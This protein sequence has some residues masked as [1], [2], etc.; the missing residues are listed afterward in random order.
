MKEVRLVEINS[1][2]NSEC[3]YFDD[4]ERIV[5]DPERQRGISEFYSEKSKQHKNKVLSRG[6]VCI[7]A[8]VVI[9]S[10]G[11]IGWINPI[12]SCLSCGFFVLRAAF[13]F[14]RFFGVD[15]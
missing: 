13:S 9:G 11:V 1:G 7:A 6:F 4:V 5:N 8:S 10:L 12:L 15:Y 2:H 14:G 3:V